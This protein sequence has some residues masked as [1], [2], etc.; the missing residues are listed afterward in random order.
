[1]KLD[2]VRAHCVRVAKE[3]KERTLAS[4][5]ICAIA[6]HGWRGEQLVVSVRTEDMDVVVGSAP[7]LSVGFDVDVLAMTMDTYLSS[8]PGN[9]RTGQAW[10][11]GDL[12]R[13]AAEHDALTRGVIH[14][15]MAVV[16]CNRADDCIA[17]VIPYVAKKSGIVWKPLDA[18]D[19]IVGTSIG[20]AIPEMLSEAMRRA[21]FDL[22][23]VANTTG[24]EPSRYKSDLFA[25]EEI[26][27]RSR[28]D[29]AVVL[30]ARWGSEAYRIYQRSSNIRIDPPGER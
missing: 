20:G 23:A 26:H 27:R 1:M 25:A 28:G 21:A 6:L 11:K 15:V 30:Y 14:E 18:L 7:I 8:T 19:G 3:E 24:E 17:E 10:R 13:E 2:D 29:A 9:P 22:S 16:A 4:S 5:E 12:G